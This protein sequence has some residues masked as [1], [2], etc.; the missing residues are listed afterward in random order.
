MT[1]LDYLA[2]SFLS[3]VAIAS[4]RRGRALLV[5]VIILPIIE[6][7]LA[8]LDA[9]AERQR[10]LTGQRNLFEGLRELAAVH[11]A[12]APT[13]R[14]FCR[15]CNVERMCEYQKAVDAGIASGLSGDKAVERAYKQH[16]YPRIAEAWPHLRQEP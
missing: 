6:F 2:A 8:V 10:A 15:V 5:R 14:Q 16:L 12:R 1:P 4:F 11:G 13:W 7:M 9:N 3:L